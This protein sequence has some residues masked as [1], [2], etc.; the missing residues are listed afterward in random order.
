VSAVTIAHPV[1]TGYGSDNL[2]TL[3]PRTIPLME[4]TMQRI[5]V[6]RRYSGPGN[7]GGGL[8]NTGATGASITGFIHG[9][10]PL[11]VPAHDS[12]TILLDQTYNTVAYPQL[13][14][15]KGKGS[16]IRLS[17]AEALFDAHGEKG[18]RNDIEGK[19]MLGDYDIFHPDGG[20]RRMFRPLWIRT[21][22]Y[23]QVHIVTGNEPVVI[24]DLY[25]MYC[26]YP[27]K[28]E[29]SFTCNDTSLKR[30]WEVGWRTAR[31]CAGETYFDCPYYEQLQY[32]ADTRIQSLIS[33]Y[34]TGDDR[35]MRKAITDFYNSRV[36]E[37]LTQGRYPSNRLQVIPP[38]SLWWISMI[39]DYWMHRSD[40]VFVREKLF[41][42]K[43]VLDWYEKR[44]ESDKG[45]LG[46]MTWWNFVDWDTH[47]DGGTPDGATDGNSSVVTLQLAYSLHQAA[48][49]FTYFGDAVAAAHYKGVA[50]LLVKRTYEQCFD[51]ARGEMANTPAK[52]SFSQH[53]SI[54]GVL[55]GSIPDSLAPA[56]MKRVLTD[57]TLSQATF[58]YRFYL[59]RALTRAGMA[60]LY[61][62][63]LTPW[64]GMIA[65]GLTTFA[66]QPD[67]T[68]S[69]CHA[70][71]A[72]PIY[73]FLATICGIKPASP[74]FSSVEVR[75]ALGELKEAHGTMPHPKGMITVSLVRKGEHGISAEIEL[76]PSTPGKFYWNGQE[77]VLHPG[78][79]EIDL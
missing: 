27:F 73:D 49:L 16:M 57:T 78:K 13:I 60:D 2:W 32:E 54:M 34:I 26:G 20:S 79:Q 52:K 65:N 59:T 48:A 7:R 1:P 21:Y 42:V 68:R 41:A 53:A 37:G 5:P 3:V 76:P 24:D 14:V 47:F 70:W 66:E 67:P 61:Y 30:L 28:Q 19:K 43:G 72:S 44:I 10:R 69:D 11:V 25:G 4:E 12:V 15:S 23:L 33:L 58:Y 50:D 29:A 40:D 71:S 45:M 8:G 75:P 64:R 77:K 51:V 63:S 17:Y 36:A 35:L 74:G 9:D 22:R 55:T 38:F 56:V 62:A 46:P 6:V 18:N 31:L 39:Y